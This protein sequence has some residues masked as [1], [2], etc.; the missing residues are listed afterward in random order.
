[1]RRQKDILQYHIMLFPGMVFL[2]IF[3]ILPLFGTVIAFQDFIPAKGIW[4]SNWVGFD[5]FTYMFQ[6]DDSKQIFFN[7]LY[8]SLMKIILNLLIPVA[9]AIL[10][11]ELLFLK[12]KRWIQTIIYFPHFMSWVILAGILSD[13]LS[14]NGIFNHIIQW[15]GGE[16]ILFM[17]SNFWFPLVIIGSDVWKEFGFNAIIFLAA[18][19]A[20]NPALYEAAEIDGANRMRKIW[21]VTLPGIMPTIVLI[22][23]LNIGQVLNAGFEQILNLY[24]P[25]VYS[26]GD[27]IDT[28]V[29]RVGLL[30]S[31]YGLA[32]AVGSLK[33][34]IGFVLI[35]ISY[36]LAA[37][38]A[39]YRI[40]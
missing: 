29:Y 2:L 9:A 24:S 33:S 3:S 40:F 31:Q 10:L 7:T 12:L 26:S 15:F 22:A 6:L 11:H 13:M 21:S 39:N 25:L 28:Y 19:T 27:I 37:K 34:F 36:R 5:N 16:P 23:T 20:I 18:L 38:Y 17:G 8:I 1:M 14:A 35:F 32:T 4:H 30:E